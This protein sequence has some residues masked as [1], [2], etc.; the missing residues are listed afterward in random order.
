M[1][2]D[3]LDKDDISSRAKRFGLIKRYANKI[4][5]RVRDVKVGKKPME[6]INFEELSIC[7]DPRVKRKDRQSK[8]TMWID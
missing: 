3:R 7:K 2:S 4:E 1:I 6:N 5:N 8:G